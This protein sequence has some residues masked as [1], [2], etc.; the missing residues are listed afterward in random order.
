MATTFDLIEVDAAGVARV[1]G[2]RFR[3]YELASEFVWRHWPADEIHH[4]HPS[5]SR[6]QVEAALA[7]YAEH[8]AQ[9][10]V[11]IGRAEREFQTSRAAENAKFVEEMA[12]NQRAYAEQREAI[13]RDYTGQYVAFAFGRVIAAGQDMD[14]VCATLDALDPQPRS[15]AVF[16]AGQLEP[17]FELLDL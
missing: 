10:D 4:Q 3:V 6:E 12:A 1:A 15:D 9:I 13:L 8:S 5:L 11:E 16:L 14:T 17:R 7:Y 2:T